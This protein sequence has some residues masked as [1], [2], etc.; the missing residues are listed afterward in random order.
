MAWLVGNLHLSSAAGGED[1]SYFL[2]FSVQKI[3]CQTLNLK[4]TSSIDPRTPFTK[5]GNHIPSMRIIKL[6]CEMPESLEIER[7][8]S[9]IVQTQVDIRLLGMCSARP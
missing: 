3:H 8:V 5:I 4:P 1:R 2:N 6:S 7:I 9:A